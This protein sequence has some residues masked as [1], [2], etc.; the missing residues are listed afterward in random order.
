[1][2]SKIVWPHT[3]KKGNPFGGV[4]GFRPITITFHNSSFANIADD[5]KYALD[6]LVELAKLDNVDAMSFDGSVSPK[7]LFDH[8][9]ADEECIG[10]RTIN[11]EGK[12]TSYYGVSKSLLEPN[13]IA[14]LLS[15]YSSIEEEEY[16]LI[17]QEILEAKSHGALYRDIFVT[18]SAFLLKNK[19]KLNELNICTPKEALKIIGLYLRM[20]EK[21]E[22]ISHIEGIEQFTTSKRMFFQFLSRGLLPN[23]WKYLS[24]LGLHDKHEKLISLGWSVLNRYS[25]ALQAR[26]EIGRLFYMPKTSSSEDQ[27][28][29]HFDYLTILLTAALDVQALI[30]NE[31]YNLGLKEN[32]CGLRRDQFN[33]AINRNPSTSNF[34]TLLNNNR[35]FINILHDLRNKI[36]SVSLKSDFQVAETYPD[37]LLER[38]YQFDP[39][40][41]WGIQKRNI[42][43][44]INHDDPVPSIDYSVDIFNL[45][46]GLVNE[47]TKLINSIMEETKIEKYMDSSYLSEIL[48]NPPV[49]M[50]PYIQTYLLLA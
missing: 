43:V 7:I 44:I 40:D 3:L 49:D 22:W 20:N 48:I 39:S 1:M 12:T 5:E 9:S 19:D 46:H 31:V 45:A 47:A 35:N 15:F 29:Y 28:A 41:H 6:I 38:I 17:R 4:D 37:E 32:N 34:K 16:R 30:I 50:I 8:E 24:G 36:H 27:T 11:T 21:F 25:R 13:Y 33:K 14:N 23:S 2:I 18:S 42:T 10:L 26:D